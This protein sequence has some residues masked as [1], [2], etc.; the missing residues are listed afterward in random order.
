MRVTYHKVLMIHA[1]R[2]EHKVKWRL[3][4]CDLLR[5]Q[6]VQLADLHLSTNPIIHLVIQFM[7]K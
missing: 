1:V 3:E 4:G 2:G 6:P 5:L 7:K